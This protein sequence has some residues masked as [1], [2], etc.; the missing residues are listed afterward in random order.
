VPCRALTAPPRAA[1]P[2][3][4]CLAS[5]GTNTFGCKQR[6]A[7]RG[8]CAALILHNRRAGATCPLEI[9]DMSD[10][11]CPPN[12]GRALPFATI[13]EAEGLQLRA[14]LRRGRVTANLSITRGRAKTWYQSWDGTSMAAPH[15]SGAAARVW[16]AHPRCSNADVRAALRA[17][18]RDLGPR[19]RDKAS[20]W[21]LVQAAAA[22]AALAAMP[23]A[24]PAPKPK[25]DSS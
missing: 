20:G 25:P 13:S 3:Q 10:R 1:A 17:T 16:A 5:R 18:A 2:P 22:E 9:G 15:V 23:C 8:R 7:Q 21:G 6:E 11:R 12:G 4:I 24:A 14:A 19:G